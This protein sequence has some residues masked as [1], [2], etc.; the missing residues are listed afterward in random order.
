M[1]E[2]VEKKAKDRKGKGREV[3]INRFVFSAFLI[4]SGTYNRA[5]R[6]I[7]QF[8][9]FYSPL[10]DDVVDDIVE[11]NGSESFNETEEVDYTL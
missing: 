4:D 1:K 8:R 5:D 9:L 3:E 2:I 7:H 6:V 10:V 11:D